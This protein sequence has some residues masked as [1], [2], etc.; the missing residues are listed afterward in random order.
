M[1]ATENKDKENNIQRPANTK[2]NKANKK[3]ENIKENVSKKQEKTT[4]K[5]VK[6]MQN[7]EKPE[8]KKQETK[9]EQVVFKNKTKNLRK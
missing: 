9:E 2:D 8:K 6:R 5:N 1:S 7:F 3:V 4:N